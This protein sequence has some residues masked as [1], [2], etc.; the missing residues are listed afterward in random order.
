MHSCTRL[1]VKVVSKGKGDAPLE[2]QPNPENPENPKNLATPATAVTDPAAIRIRVL[3]RRCKKIRGRL[4]GRISA[5]WLRISCSNMTVSERA[6]SA[7][8][9]SAFKWAK[10]HSYTSFSIFFSLLFSEYSI[11]F[12]TLLVHSTLLHFS[13]LLA[14]T[15]STEQSCITLWCLTFSLHLINYSSNFYYGFFPTPPTRSQFFSSASSRQFFRWTIWLPSCAVSGDPILSIITVHLSI[16]SLFIS[17]SF[18][19]PMN[20]NVRKSI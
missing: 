17:A 12:S 8:S 20:K 9:S 13:L 15:S 6:T 4:A 19:V 7:S 16:R 11:P 2:N 10:F 3:R 5:F 1:F 14:P 18:W